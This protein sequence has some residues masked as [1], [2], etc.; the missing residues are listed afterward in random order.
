MRLLQALALPANEG[1]R[2]ESGWSNGDLR[3]LPP[4]RRTWG[5]WV[6][7]SWWS[8]FMFSLTNWQIGASLIA[9]GLSVWQSMVLIVASRVLHA[10]LA[11]ANGMPGG[12]WHIGFPVFSRA[13]W[14]VYG[15]FLPVAMRTFLGLF[16]FAF[17]T[18]FGGLCTAAM[19]AAM[20]E[21]FRNL[22]ATFP[23]SSHVT[24]AQLLGWL[25]FNV[26]MLPVLAVKPERAALLFST[27]NA[28][29]F[30]TLVSIMIWS[31]VAAHGAGPMLSHSSPDMVSGS[32]GWIVVKGFCT[33]LAVLMAPMMSQS[34]FS[35]F[36]RK[37]RNQI[38]GQLVAFIGLGSIMP[39]FGC[40]A[41]SATQKIWGEPAWNPPLIILQWMARDYS[42]ATR[43]A[44][45]FAATGLMINLLSLNT[46]E[47]GY[48]V[49][50]DLAG[51][52]PR[53]VN[54]RRGAYIGLIA[55]MAMC[56]WQLLATANTLVAVLN[57]FAIFFAPICAIQLCDY[58][59]LRHRRLKLSDL[60]H[61]HNN[62]IY[63][64][65]YGINFRT[66]VAWAMAWVPLAPGLARTADSRYAMR[67]NMLVD[68]IDRFYALNVLFS[69]TVAFVMYY[70][71]CSIWPLPRLGEID[72]ED[73]FGTFSPPEAGM[74][75]Q[76]SDQSPDS[77]STSAKDDLKVTA[78][79][80]APSPI[81][82]Q[83]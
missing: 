69:F 11:V 39:L 34:D 8:V 38:A 21:G 2:S 51:L 20:S 74:L 50:M 75:D 79:E 64:F 73:I 58:F 47:S 71:L 48:A 41:A 14:G 80:K 83:L 13:V 46:V 55:S 70:I 43:A 18:W 68:G 40:L 65:S 28:V 49:G 66:A 33:S 76:A 54:I 24:L 67:A 53:Y 10:G 45:F 63:Y 16:A 36:A 19:L 31:L 5:T 61:P 25:I 56:P 52:F 81:Q 7:V 6:F 62:G 27:F 4:H 30:V 29:S 17:N 23:A 77:P 37:P 44:A 3:P 1:G 22:P 60:Y 32:H 59:I 78:S 35:R 82:T 12:E 15:A 9:L 57:G 26:L 72:T 42:P